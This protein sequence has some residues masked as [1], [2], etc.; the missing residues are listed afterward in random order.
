MDIRP[1]R[2]DIDHDWALGEISAYFA[3]PPRPGTPDGD[4]FEILVDLVSAYEDTRFPLPE[5][6]PVEALK[7]FMES[8]GK[9]Q[10]DLA[11]LVG[12]RPRASE[13]LN[14]RRTMT[15]ETI[16]RL[17]RDWGVPA[18]LLIVPYRRVA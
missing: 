2:T 4:R 17:H 10:S 9:T 7:A 12:S 11:E 13:I 1:I 16:H 8:A 3:R 5:L 15:I 6:D 14:R 18:E